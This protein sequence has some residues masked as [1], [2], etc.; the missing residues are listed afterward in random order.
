MS[1]SENSVDPAVLKDGASEN[2]NAKK[3]KSHARA[4]AARLASVQ[5]MYQILQNEQPMRKVV[6][7]YLD[8]R[9]D[10]EIDGQKLENPDEFLL[11]RILYGLDDRMVEV[12]EI[13]KANLTKSSTQDVESL[14]KSILLCGVYELL[15]HQE[16][17][18]PIIINDYLNVAHGFYGQSEVSLINGVLDSVASLLR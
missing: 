3:S 5:A 6:Q 2:M 10:V 17:D 16:I 7:E 9:S 11:K 12:Q 13:L 1:M 15:A 18:S 14:L 4:L 8:Y